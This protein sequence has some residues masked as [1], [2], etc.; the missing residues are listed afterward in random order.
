M[1]IERRFLGWG[2]FFI[3]AGAVALAVRGGYLS[4]DQASQVWRLWPLLLVGL[5]VA[6]ILGRSS[7]G[8]LGGLIIAATFGLL[9]GSALVGGVGQV[10]CGLDL[11][12][13]SAAGDAEASLGGD[14][15]EG[16]TI[17]VK[18][19][20]GALQVT[21]GP[22]G[23]WSLAYPQDRPPRVEE[24]EGGVK[25]S[26][27]EGSIF[28][29]RSDWRLTLPAD[30]TLALQVEANAGSADLVLTNAHLSHFSGTFNAGSFRVDLSGAT[31]GGIDLRVNAGSGTAILPA[32]TFGGR[33]DVN[34]GS[35][36]VCAP[37]GTGLRITT[38][39]T[40][41]SNDFASSGLVLTG[42][43]WE[44]PGY[45]SAATKIDL[46]LNANAASLALRGDG[47]CS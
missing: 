32:G 27:G 16:A 8:W 41:A 14:L 45:A 22:V 6:I 15:G 40:L 21:T 35:L 25:L 47:G 1:R 44:S 24:S 18:R 29:A 13:R 38:N 46:T 37:D 31:L 2:V 9:V 3:V 7:L 11:D 17:E 4:A 19:D 30:R 34:A 12:D 42:S 10:G 36:N 26:P 23:G 39:G 43:T 5:G 20:C 33:I 28:G